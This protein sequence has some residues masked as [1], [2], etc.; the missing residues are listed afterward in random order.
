M[1]LRWCSTVD[2]GENTFLPVLVVN[3]LRG[4]HSTRQEAAQ[5]SGA[6]SC[7]NLSCGWIHG[8]PIIVLAGAVHAFEWFFVK[9]DGEPV[10]NGGV[11]QH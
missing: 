8:T 3:P 2:P 10:V 11:V 5:P 7:A 1:K 4:A 9:Q 6:L